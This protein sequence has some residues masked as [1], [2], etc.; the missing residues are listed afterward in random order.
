[1][2]DLI[3]II[4]AADEAGCL[5]GTG[6]SR[7][8]NCAAGFPQRCVAKKQVVLVSDESQA[9]FGPPLDPLA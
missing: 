4:P 9:A 8:A 3:K 2:A 1:M 6:N 5:R 7:C